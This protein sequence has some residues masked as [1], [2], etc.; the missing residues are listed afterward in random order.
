MKKKNQK[1]ESSIAKN[2]RARF[3]Y[4]IEDDYECGMKLQGWEVKSIRENHARIA[5]GYVFVKGG[6]VFIS[7]MSITPVMSVNTHITPEST[8]V[9]KL[10]LNRTEIDKLT[11]L[12]ERKGYTLVPL[13]LYWKDGFVKLKIGLGLGKKNHDKR[14]TEKERSWSK[15]ASRIMKTNLKS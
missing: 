10:L 2:A 5:E 6:E 4:F 9:R 11:G 3:E 8:R 7:G 1:K 13:S 12:V 14:Q 15:E